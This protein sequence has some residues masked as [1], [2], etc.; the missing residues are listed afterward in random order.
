MDI[1]SST[2]LAGVGGVAGTL[3]SILTAVSMNGVIAE[4]NI[5]RIAASGTTRAL[6]EQQVNVPVVVGLDKRFD[7]AS[8]RG[9]RLLWCGMLC[10]ALG[11]IL[12]AVAI[13]LAA[14]GK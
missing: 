1:W 11:F 14:Q 5:A 7:E 8:K 10:L 13:W 6:A 2:I 4:L 9:T 12:Q 3:G